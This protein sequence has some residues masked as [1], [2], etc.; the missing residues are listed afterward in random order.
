LAE[1]L[2][3]CASLA[4]LS[5]LDNPPITELMNSKDG[6][7]QEEA[8]A[9]F[10]SLMT[11]VRVSHTIIAID[12]E[13]P[14]ADSNEIV[15]ALASQV[16][17]YTLKNMEHCALKELE[18]TPASKG[19][20]DKDAPE[21]LLHIVG[22]M[23][24]YDED[25]DEDEP[26]PDDDYLMGGNAIVKALGV[27]LSTADDKSRAASRNISPIRTPSGDGPATPKVGT[28]ARKPV[29]YKKP[30]DVSKQLLESARKI[31]MRLKPALIREDRAGNDFNYGK[32]EDQIRHVM[33]TD[34]P[35]RRPSPVP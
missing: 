19:G 23:E 27:C 14:S 8:C 16:I 22:H 15:K 28:T 12:I 7:A 18:A 5:I 20:P 3:E 25:H 24:G 32:L 4:H 11:A 17:A 33:I 2:P 35:Y 31:R 30:R 10:A 1:I 13:V 6:P 21:I 9:L 34:Q 29:A 26:A